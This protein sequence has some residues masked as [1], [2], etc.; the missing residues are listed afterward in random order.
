MKSVF[1]GL[2]VVA[3]V[4]VAGYCLWPRKPSL[5]A[6]NPARMAELQVETWKKAKARH[7]RELILTLYSIYSGQYG[8]SPLTALKLAGGTAEAMIRFHSA[9]DAADQEKA[10]DPLAETFA[11]L[12]DR[13]HATFDSSAA[14]QMEF[15]I[16]CL[17]AN[18]GRQAELATAISEELGLLYGKS[19]GDC[20]PAAKKFAAAMKAAGSGRWAESRSAGEGAWAAL[21]AVVNKPSS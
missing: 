13:T 2:V 6:F 17:R 18:G 16:W 1:R 12:K 4:V 8:I 5:S 11:T 10:I 7:R 9:P 20:L 19:P 21:L 3:V 15:Q 14:A